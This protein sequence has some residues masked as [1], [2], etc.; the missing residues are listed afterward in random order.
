MRTIAAWLVMN[1]KGSNMT[2]IYDKTGAI[3]RRSRNLRGLLEHA[4]RVVP[5]SARLERL[6]SSGP[7][8][9]FYRLCVR[10]HNGDIAVSPFSDWRVAADWCRSRRSWGRLA[11]EG[12]PDFVERADA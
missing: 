4:R 6:H 7:D 8:T 9:G 1:W 12:L 11:F 10:F 2:L 3:V 5:V